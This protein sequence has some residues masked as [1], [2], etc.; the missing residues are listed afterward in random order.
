MIS[1]P[2]RIHVLDALRGFAIVSIMLLHNIEHFDVY[3]TPE[4]IPQWMQNLDGIIWSSLFFMFSGKSYA[5]FALLFGVTY[6][7]QSNNQAQR[8]QKFDGRFA[9][10]MLLLFAFGIFNSAFFQGDV[11][12]IYA[13]IGLLL[14]PITKLNTRHIL[15]IIIGLLLL[16]VE[17]FKLWEAIKQPDMPVYDPKSWTYFGRMGAYIYDSS[18]IE[19]VKGN[20]TNGKKAVILWNWENGRFFLIAALF[21]LGFLMGK[22]QLF[23]WSESSKRFWIR[24]LVISTAAFMPLLAIERMLP[25]TISS[26]AVKR[27]V[28]VLISTWSDLSFMLILVSGFTILFEVTSFRKSLRYFSSFGKMSLSNYILQS[29]V[30]SCIYYGFGLGLYKYTSPTYGLLLGI[31][32]TILFG[33]FCK[34]WAGNFKHGPFETVWHKLTWVGTNK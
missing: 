29:V 6:F 25:G 22:H 4:N 3:F 27:P 33:L 17:W 31:G 9:W 1:N 21:L 24:M 34:W 20:L 23:R 26:E 16:P 7:I 15:I 32:L 12:T 13:V 19:T 10:R 11:L 28:M 14:I 8:G 2:T 5:I 30:G 18:F